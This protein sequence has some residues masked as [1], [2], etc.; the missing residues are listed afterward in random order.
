[1]LAQLF[2]QRGTPDYL[3]SDNGAE[4]TAKRCGAGCSG[5]A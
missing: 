5:S 1:M 3:R 4:F 2:V